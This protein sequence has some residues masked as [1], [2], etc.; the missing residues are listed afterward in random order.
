M[1]SLWAASAGTM[2]LASVAGILYF[3]KR[4]NKA[5]SKAAEDRHNFV[6][7]FVPVLVISALSLWL[8]FFR[9]P[10]QQ[11]AGGRLGAA[12]GR[13]IAAG[14][15]GAG[16]LGLSPISKKFLSGFLLGMAS[17]TAYR[18]GLG[19]SVLCR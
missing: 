5:K 18:N 14:V 2:G 15:E 12:A 6:H 1:S 8:L 17:I 19:S 11:S 3:V 13:A 7:L 10:F 4:L 9:N 16:L